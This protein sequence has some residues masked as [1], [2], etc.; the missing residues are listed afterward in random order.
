M[1]LIENW[2]GARIGWLTTDFVKLFAEEVVNARNKFI[3]RE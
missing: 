1:V 2:R 3:K